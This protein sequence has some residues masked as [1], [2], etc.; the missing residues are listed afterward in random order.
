[1]ANAR[2]PGDRAGGSWL[3]QASRG[4]LLAWRERRVARRTSRESLQ[5]YRELEATR[6]ELSAVARYEQVIARRTG[7]DGAGVR[8]VLQHAEDSFASWPVERPL[9]FRDVVQYL[10][11]HEC[12]TAD[13]SAVGTRTRLTTIIAEVIPRD[14]WARPL[15]TRLR[16]PIASRYSRGRDPT[17]PPAASL[18]MTDSSPSTAP[19]GAASPATMTGGEALVAGL[20]AHGVD[21]VFGLP[22]VQTYGLFDALKRAEDRV[23]VICPRHE[24]SCAYMALGYAVSTG[25]PGVFSVVPGPGLMNAAAGL[26]TAYGLNAPVL[27]LTGEVPAAWIGRGRGHLHEMPD[28]LAVLRQLTKWSAL[29]DEPGQAQALLALAFQQMTAGRQGPVGLEMP[30]DHF[31]KKVPVAAAG[32]LPPVPPPVADPAAVSEAARLLAAARAPM[33]M[34]GGGALA[35]APEVRALAEALGAP[36][37]AFRV[38]LGILSSEHELSHT[39]A[40]GRALWDDTDVLLAIGTRLEIPDFRW[41]SKPAGLKTIRIDIDPREFER[42]PAEV[43]LLADAAPATAALAAALARLRPGPQPGR[44]AASRAA[45]AATEVAVGRL[46]PQIEFLHAIRAA[47]PRDG[48]F[49]DEMCQVGYTAWLGLPVY[50][51]RHFVTSGYQ[52]TLGYGFPTALGVK[53]A[54]PDRAVV[55]VAGDGGFMF[56]CAELATAAQYGIGVTLVVF[57]NGSFGNVRRDQQRAFGRRIASDLLNPD[58]VRLGESFGVPSCRAE[59]PAALERELKAAFGRPGPALIVVPVERDSE[60]SPWELIIPGGR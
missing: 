26:L 8:Q 32:T 24:Q 20:L 25:R 18:V 28:Q 59:G 46:T 43:E 11:V 30:W 48:Y 50:E 22:G 23:R 7:L 17:T 6:P 3:A 29:I 4:V 56:A 53:V 36:V 21:A 57:D 54:H 51:P 44:R 39:I 13:A 60:A 19:A 37:V 2:A 33:I 45:R 9:R 10:V 55:S 47:L 58:F 5:L 31:T 40:S 38:G 14:L 42:V 1:M 27:C 12:L 52:G 49:V 41:R 35:A 16:Y 34:V 15:R